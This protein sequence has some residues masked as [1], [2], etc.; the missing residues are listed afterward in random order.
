MFGI[1]LIRNLNLDFNTVWLQMILESNQRMA[2]E[3]SPLLTLARQ[4]AKAANLV[5]AQRS[6]GNPPREPSI[7]NQDQAKRA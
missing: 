5:A 1:R 4:E 3:G 6:V 7:G 2:Y